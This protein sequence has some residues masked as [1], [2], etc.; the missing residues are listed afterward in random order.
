MKSSP[1]D[2]YGTGYRCVTIVLEQRVAMMRIGASPRKEA[3][4]QI[5]D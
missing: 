2:P 5:V 1:Y 3:G 4:I